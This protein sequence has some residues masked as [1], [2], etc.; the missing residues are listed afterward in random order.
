MAQHLA[1]E[2]KEEIAFQFN[3]KRNIELTVPTSIWIGAFNVN[4]EPLK[5]F[6]IEKRK[7]LGNGL[8][9]MFTQVLRDQVNELLTNYAEIRQKLK[10]DP[11][12]IEDIFDIREWMDTIPLTVKSLD[13]VMQR[14]KIEFDIL[15]S[16]KWNLSDE[17]FQAKWQA[18]GYPLEIELQVSF[19]LLTGAIF[20]SHLRCLLKMEIHIKFARNTTIKRSDTAKVHV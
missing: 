12:S 5:K 15:D 2:V 17:D 11:R 7:D 10:E 6:L 1:S 9:S 3:I 14:L 19:K 16:F 20:S 13:G 4:V 18:I 8:L